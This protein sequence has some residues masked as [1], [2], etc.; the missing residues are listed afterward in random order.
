MN[1]DTNEW[2]TA[3]GEATCLGFR[4]RPDVVELTDTAR[5]GEVVLPI[6]H[7]AFRGFVEAAERGEFRD[8]L[9]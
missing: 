6:P 4:V 8:L 5:P 7:E 2:R 3:C 1:E 9:P